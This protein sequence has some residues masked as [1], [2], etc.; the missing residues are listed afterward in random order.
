MSTCILFLSDGRP[1]DSISGRVGALRPE[2]R[3]GLIPAAIC[4]LVSKVF[5]TLGCDEKRL[6]FHT[7]GFGSEDE[8]EVLRSMASTLPRAVGSFHNAK[9]SVGELLETFT[10][11]STSVSSTRLTST[12]GQPRVLRPVLHQKSLDS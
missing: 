10:T 11:F 4:E 12:A 9:L 8:F 1:S 7:V 3:K 2:E 6:D 5:R